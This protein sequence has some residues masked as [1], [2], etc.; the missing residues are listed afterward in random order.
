M[1]RLLFISLFVL[2][3]QGCATT[4]SQYDSTLESPEKILKKSK[5]LVDQQ[6]W[7]DAQLILKKG[8]E[9]Y[10]KSS[11]LKKRQRLVLNQWNARKR[12][13]EDWMLV[14]D[15]EA[16]LLKHPLLVSL[17]QSDPN[18]F[19]LKSRLLFLDSLLATKRKAL[20]LC[21]NTQIKLED[22]LAKRCLEA[23]Q[24]IT[25]T[26]E[27]KKLL[28]QI[29]HKQTGIKKKQKMRAQKDAERN[30]A[31]DRRLV[32]QEVR[33]N[34]QAQFYYEA[35]K[36][37]DP[38]LVTYTN[39]KELEVLMAEAVAGRDYQVDQLIKHGDELYRDEHIQEAV[40]IW[41]QAASLNPKNTGIVQRI[42]RARKVIDNLEEIRSE[43]ST[44]SKVSQ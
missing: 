7:G 25:P 12:R 18:D 44:S 23:A 14:Y 16:L 43:K 6:Q 20:V 38:L 21:A 29:D 41:E 22:K 37:L 15:I 40:A 39:D 2:L 10:P 32:L 3:I 34:M 8:V 26:T 17:S 24:K 11:E 30:R 4:I 9:R 33:A 13:L 5:S 42:T 19:L 28:K 31:E 36:L 35:I 27:E 1:K